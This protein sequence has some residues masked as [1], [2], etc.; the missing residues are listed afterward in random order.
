MRNFLYFLFL[1]SSFALKAQSV[2]EIGV[3]K[4]VGFQADSGQDVSRAQSIERFMEGQTYAFDGNRYRMSWKFKLEEGSYE[5]NDS[6]VIK[7]RADNAIEAQSK[8]FGQVH[9]DTV[10]IGFDNSKV[11]GVAIFARSSH[12]VP[13]ISSRKTIQTLQVET[14]QV[15]K[16]WKLER[17]DPPKEG[18]EFSV[19]ESKEIAPYLQGEFTRLLRADGS[20]RNTSKS[21][22]VPKEGTWELNETKDALVLDKGALN[23]VHY[24]IVA[25]TSTQLILVDQ[26]EKVWTY[27]V[28]E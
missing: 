27:S 26:A 25:C 4:F 13:E 1:V 23:Q 8:Q 24:L 2:S 10:K 9:S 20:Y 28:L 16:K 14:A 21:E 6:G 3:W 17:I 7:L 5:L 19:I 12:E 11:L 22:E 15:T 18:K